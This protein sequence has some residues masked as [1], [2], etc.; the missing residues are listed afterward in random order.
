MY[1]YCGRVNRIS[2]RSDWFFTGERDKI[3]Y[4]DKD[5]STG[6]RVGALRD[7]LSI[8]ERQDTK[9]ECKSNYETANGGW[10]VLSISG[11]SHRLPDGMD[12]RGGVL[13]VYGGN[14]S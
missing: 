8:A 3:A 11:F 5:D 2:N 13:L 14:A 7:F 1:S 6:K 12:L 4:R 9:D 10:S